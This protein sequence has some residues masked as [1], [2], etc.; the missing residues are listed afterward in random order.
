M[1]KNE[2]VAESYGDVGSLEAAFPCKLEAMLF[3]CE[4]G[5]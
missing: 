3:C 2:H 4:P 1:S 5:T